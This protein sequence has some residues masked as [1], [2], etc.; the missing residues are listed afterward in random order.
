MGMGKLY[1]ERCEVGSG[2]AHG[3]AD[4]TAAGPVGC[5]ATVETLCRFDGATYRPFQ[6]TTTSCEAGG[7]LDDAT[8]R[9]MFTICSYGEG[10]RCHLTGATMGEAPPR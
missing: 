7:C 3:F 6:A 8:C 5:E 9:L 4:L 2:A 10:G 1:G